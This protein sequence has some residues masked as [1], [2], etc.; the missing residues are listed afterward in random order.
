MYTPPS[1][2]VDDFEKL[3]DFIEENSFGILV[4]SRDDQPSATH[5]PLLIDR[6]T[7]GQG[8]IV[9]HM[10]IANS[11]WKEFSDQEVLVIFRGPHTYISPTWYESKNV[12]PTWNYTA[13]HV[14]GTLR[15]TQDSDDL[16]DIVR[17]YVDFYEQDLPNPWE[18]QN[19][20]D[21]F[22]AQL[23]KGIVG[24][25]IEIQSL[26]GKFKLSQ[27][28]DDNRRRGVIDALNSQSGEN[29]LKI[30]KLMQATLGDVADECTKT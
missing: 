28:H 7:G 18:L 13:V 21:D 11:Q 12:V 29:Q 19:A 1:F 26:E 10:A 6:K 8:E 23:L 25:R 24:F 9:G 4:S 17:R 5:L 27:N 16:L 2:Q 20:D 22:V 3:C 15:V 30:A 14:R